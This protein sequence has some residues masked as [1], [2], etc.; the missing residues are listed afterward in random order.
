MQPHAENLLENFHAR[1]NLI[2]LLLQKGNHLV[3]MIFEQKTN[4]TLTKLE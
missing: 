3:L 4:V 1:E 2:F